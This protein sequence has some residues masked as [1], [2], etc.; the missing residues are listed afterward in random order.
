MMNYLV[1]SCKALDCIEGAQS[2]MNLLSIMRFVELKLILLR[3]SL[4]TP[5]SEE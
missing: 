2:I 4:Q 5:L 3:E 1:L